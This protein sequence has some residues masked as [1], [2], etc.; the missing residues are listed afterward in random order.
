VA[1][2]NGPQDCVEAARS[3]YRERRDVIVP[4]LAAA[5]WQMPSP[6]GSMFAWAP[7][8]P[9]Y[10]HMGSL[11]FSKLLLERARVAV[12]PGIGFG[13][14]GDG[15]VRIALVENTQRLRQAVRNIRGFLQTE[16]NTPSTRAEQVPA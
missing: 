14:H 16:S 10:V 2:L 15:H 9:R 8:P 11:D 1:A 4:G 7:I 3:L 5:G 13:E 12:A 6:R